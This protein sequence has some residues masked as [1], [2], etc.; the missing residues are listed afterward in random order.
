MSQGVNRCRAH[1]NA[2]PLE[3]IRQLYERDGLTVRSISERFGISKRYVYEL[4]RRMGVKMRRGPG[5]A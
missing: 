1:V 3:R 5:W 4:L 2:L